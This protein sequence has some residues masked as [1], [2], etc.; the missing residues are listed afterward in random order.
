MHPCQNVLYLLFNVILN[1]KLKGN[2]I[3]N[4]HHE[5]HCSFLYCTMLV[6]IITSNFTV[7]FYIHNAGF[8]HKP[9]MNQ[10]VCCVQ[11]LTVC[12]SGFTHTYRF[13]PPKRRTPSQNSLQPF[14]AQKE[15]LEEG[16]RVSLSF[17]FP[18]CRFQSTWWANLGKKC[19]WRR[20]LQEPWVIVLECL[21]YWCLFRS[22][23]DHPPHTHSPL[24]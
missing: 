11:S 5:F 8:R 20:I 14:W 19:K 17:P 22:M 15:G 2:K 21:L 3:E 12:A 24:G 23:C 10:V 7:L 13:A 6:L 16:P 18:V 9:K 4:Y 1:R